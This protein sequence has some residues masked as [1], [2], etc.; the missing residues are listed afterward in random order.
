MAFKASGG[1]LSQIFFGKADHFRSGTDLSRVF[2]LRAGNGHRADGVCAAAEAFGK[3]RRFA[4]G[5]CGDGEGRGIY[6]HNGFI[7]DEPAKCG[8]RRELRY[9]GDVEPVALSGFQRQFAD[10]EVDL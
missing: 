9:E 3:D 10:T 1:D 2:F 5:K 8:D 6:A 7:G 4:G